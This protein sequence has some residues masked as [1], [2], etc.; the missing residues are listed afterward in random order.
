LPTNKD[1]KV[2]GKIEQPIKKT[3]LPPEVDW[4]T[5]AKKKQK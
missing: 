1:V 4:Q 3:K 5:L 2:N